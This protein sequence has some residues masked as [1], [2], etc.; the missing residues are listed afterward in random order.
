MVLPDPGFSLGWLLIIAGALFLLVEVHTP[1]FF[2]AVPG[3]VMIILGILIL[4]GIDIFNSGWGIVIGVAIALCA[5]VFTVWMYGRITPN[6]ISTTTVSRDSLVGKEGRVKLAV[7]PNSLAG[8]VMIGSSEWSAR[9]TGAVIGAGKKVK[10]V[11]SQGV[12]VVVEE[13]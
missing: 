3:T 2:A 6:D 12:H 10:V 8:K 5:A 1:G 7:N 11:D 9:S 13:V 4:L